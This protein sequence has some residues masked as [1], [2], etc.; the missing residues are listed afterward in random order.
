MGWVLF[1]VRF[2]DEET[3]TREV[4]HPAQGHTASKL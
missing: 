4:K 3:E 2:T 1:Y